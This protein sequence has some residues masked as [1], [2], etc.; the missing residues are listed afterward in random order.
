VD[1]VS[2]NSYQNSQP[3]DQEMDQS[4]GVLSENYRVRRLKVPY[5]GRVTDRD[6]WM[7]KIIGILFHNPSL[8]LPEAVEFFFSEAGASASMY[9]RGLSQSGRDRFYRELS[10]KIGDLINAEL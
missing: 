2:L 9:W 3:E 10:Q 4:S 1:T 8:R 7:G 5:H 6:R